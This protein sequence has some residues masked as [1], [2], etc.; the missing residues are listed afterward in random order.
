VRLS[1]HLHVGRRPRALK[2]PFRCLTCGA[3]AAVI[4]TPVHCVHVS[5]TKAILALAA[6]H[7]E[8]R[9]SV[10]VTPIT[11]VVLLQLQ[12]AVPA[13]SVKI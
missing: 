3:D 4:A 2:S 11:E 10:L 8:Q 7:H 9:S 1:N 6:A 12:V 13:E 5:V